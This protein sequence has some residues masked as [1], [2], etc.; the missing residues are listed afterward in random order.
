MNE[1]NIFYSLYSIKKIQNKFLRVNA[2]LF[3]FEKSF[4]FL[5]YLEITKRDL[6]FP[7]SPTSNFF[8]KIQKN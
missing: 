3:S 2:A 5:N 4:S 8:N 6:I 7:L 1:K